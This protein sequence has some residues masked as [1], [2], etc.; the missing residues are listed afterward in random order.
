MYVAALDA[1]TSGSLT[2]RSLGVFTPFGN[3]F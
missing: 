1:L 2:T 3:P